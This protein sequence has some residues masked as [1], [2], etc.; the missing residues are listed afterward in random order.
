MSKNHIVV[1]DEFKN[2]GL[3]LWACQTIFREYYQGRIASYVGFIRQMLGISG[4]RL[5]RDDRT[6]KA[7]S[8]LKTDVKQFL[9]EIGTEND[10]KEIEFLYIFGNTFDKA[11]EWLEEAFDRTPIIMRNDASKGAMKQL[12]NRCGWI[13]GE[14]LLQTVPFSISLALGENVERGIVIPR[15]A[16]Y[17]M[18]RSIQLLVSTETILHIYEGN[19]LNPRFD[20]EIGSVS[21]AQIPEGHEAECT[22][23]MDAEG[24]LLLTV[25]NE[26]KEILL[27]KYLHEL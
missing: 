16:V 10:R 24:I 1:S 11:V 4:I 8:Q 19:Y 13:S 27:E 3:P 12:G 6:D 22:L 5:D 18:E 15:Y 21:L 26:Q 9:K 23:N 20:T 17:P 25:R 14:L 2:L 7:Q